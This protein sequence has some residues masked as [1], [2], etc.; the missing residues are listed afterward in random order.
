M[1]RH[2]MSDRLFRLMDQDR[3]RI[4]MEIIDADSCDFSGDFSSDFSGGLAPAAS[5]AA[6]NGIVE[7]KRRL[8]GTRTCSVT[9]SACRG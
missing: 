4:D 8:H 5:G 7:N 3:C 6:G 9:C 2:A 1:K